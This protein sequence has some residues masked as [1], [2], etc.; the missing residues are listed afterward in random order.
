[1]ST[2]TTVPDRAASIVDFMNEPSS[3]PER[4]SSIQVIET[5]ISWVFLTDHYAYK[6]KKPVRFEF[7]DFSAAELR[8]RACQEE[9]RLNRR[10]APEVYIDVLPITK[11]RSGAL[12]LNGRGEEVDWVVKMR[13]LPA[14]TALDVR[15]RENRLAPRES[16]A[17]AMYLADYYA[18]LLPKPLGSDDYRRALERHI[19]ANGAA[20]VGSIPAESSRLRRIQGAQLRYLNIRSE[21]I[22]DRVATGRIVD[23]HGDLRPEHIYLVG[24]P[25]VIDCIEFSEELRTVDIADELSFLSMECQRLGDGRIGEAVLSQYQ[26]VSEDEIPKTLLD[27]YAGYRALVR[28]KVSLLRNQQLV[29]RAAQQSADLIRQYLDLGDS[30][31]EKLGSPVLLIVG[32][33][34][35]TGKSTLAAKLAEALGAESLSTDLVRHS[36]LGPSNV[37]ASYG[38]GN[39]QPDIRGR[40]YDE[41][42]R[43]ASE[44]LQDRQSVVLDGTFLTNGLRMRAYDLGY[45]HSAVPLHVQCRCPRRIAQARIQQRIDTAQSE[46]EARTELYDLQARDYQ[47]PSAN[48]PSITIDTTQPIS[49]QLQTVYAELGH[50]LFD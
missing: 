34:M 13:R 7:L 35:G 18:R 12:E 49:Q 30:Y 19:R 6:L 47:P 41:L 31:A 15:L 28:A 37:P 1:M 44:R 8:H 33:L 23:G 11:G 25:I 48:D 21:L 29:G 40:V 22:N 45:R 27:F 42:L 2:T 3:Y 14:K 9:L 20:L 16:E 4:P 24:R 26:R 50:L 10:L 46:S 32:G 43:Q 38:E 5:H 17:I 39:Y 36:I